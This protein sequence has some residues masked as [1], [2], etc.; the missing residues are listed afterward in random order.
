L[1]FLGPGQLASM[2]LRTAWRRDERARIRFVWA[3]G[4]GGNFWTTAT[5]TGTRP[6]LHLSVSSASEVGTTRGTVRPVLLARHDVQL[7]LEVED[8]DGAEVVTTDL[9]GECTD[10]HTGTSASSPMAPE[11]L[12]SPLKQIQVKFVVLTCYRS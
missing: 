7:W 11:L 8:D 10:Q 3:S 2:A 4:N 5:A 1:Y 12:L 6:H 9:H